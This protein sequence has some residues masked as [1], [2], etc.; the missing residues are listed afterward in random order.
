MDD[1]RDAP[2]MHLVIVSVERIVKL[3]VEQTLVAASDSNHIMT[4]RKRSAHNRTDTGIHAR[5][6]AAACE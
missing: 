6:V 2:K 5:R 3:A 4:E 1:A